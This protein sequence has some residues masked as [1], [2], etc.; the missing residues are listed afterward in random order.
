MVE[1]TA[2]ALV[3]QPGKGG[4]ADEFSLLPPVDGLFEHFEFNLRSADVP[5][6]CFEDAIQERRG[7]FVG[8]KFSIKH[9]PF[10]PP[11]PAEA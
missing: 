6:H 9:A 2:R 5:G 4:P 10:L 3:R 7:A 8:G 1:M 11:A